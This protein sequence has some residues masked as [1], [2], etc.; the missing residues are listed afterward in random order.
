MIRINKD[1]CIGCGSC[2]MF[3]PDVFDL[4]DDGIAYIK[5]SF[6]YGANKDNIND[7]IENCPTE[8][9]YDDNKITTD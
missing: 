7:A 9:I 5:S 6:D 4:D 1:Q 8:A 2:T 3:S